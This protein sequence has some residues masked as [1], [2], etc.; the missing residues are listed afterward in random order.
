MYMKLHQ[1]ELAREEEKKKDVF[2]VTPSSTFHHSNSFVKF[3]SN[4]IRGA[5]IKPF[6]ENIK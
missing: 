3:Y 4:R 6:D 2:M 5:K 1:L